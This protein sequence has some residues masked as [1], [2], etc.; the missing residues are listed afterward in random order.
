MKF[1]TLILSYKES[2]TTLQT[3][4]ANIP[5]HLPKINSALTSRTQ[6]EVV[7]VSKIFRKKLLKIKD[8]IS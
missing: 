3:R 7:Q 6:R 1:K 2:K 4:N 5:A 8:T